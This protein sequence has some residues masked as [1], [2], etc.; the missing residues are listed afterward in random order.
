[1][2]QAQALD[3][4]ACLN[5]LGHVLRGGLTPRRLDAPRPAS[6]DDDIGC[7]P[8]V[9]SAAGARMSGTVSEVWQ[10]LSQREH[11]VSHTSLSSLLMFAL[12]VA[13]PAACPLG[14]RSVGRQRH[15]GL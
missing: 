4:G 7:T 3:Q 14:R 2:L 5:A 12:G 9:G 10:T 6:A 15:P 13:R 8:R 11:C 1:M